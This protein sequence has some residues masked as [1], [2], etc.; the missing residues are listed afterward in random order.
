M[1]KKISSLDVPEESKTSKAKTF[2]AE[3]KEILSQ[4]N[5]DRVILALQ[6]YKSTD[7]LDTLLSK[8]SVLTEDA[9]THSLLRGKSFALQ[10]LYT[11]YTIQYIQTQGI[12]QRFFSTMVNQRI[13]RHKMPH[14]AMLSLISL[15]FSPFL[16]LRETFI[17]SKCV[18]GMLNLT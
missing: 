3:M 16:S 17:K 5:F 7:N 10:M 4:A 6:S 18:C 9:N 2:L 1:L 11:V 12:V 8:T 15:I 13:L 14:A